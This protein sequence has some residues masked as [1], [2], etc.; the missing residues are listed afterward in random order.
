MWIYD[1]KK[2]SEE[3]IDNNVGFV[4]KIINID[5]GKTYIGKKLFTKSKIYQKNINI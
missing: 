4:Y 2:F 3:L 1:G 5:N